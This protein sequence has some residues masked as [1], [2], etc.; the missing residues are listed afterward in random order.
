MQEF[1]PTFTD[2]S[3]WNIIPYT[4]TGGTRSKQIAIHPYTEKQ[5]FFKGSKVVKE[6]GEIKYPT[7]F[8]SEIVSSKIGQY[9]GFTVL[10]YNIG[11]SEHN[12]QKV[13]CLSQ[14][15][16]EHSVNR[17]TEG[18]TYL[19]G[20]KPSYRPALKDHQVQYTFQFICEALNSF[21]LNEHIDNIIELV[22]F[23]SIISNS[24]RHQENWGIITHFNETL[25][26]LDKQIEISKRSWFKRN[27]LKLERWLAN[28]ISKNHSFLIKS[29]QRMLPLQSMIAPH[30]FAPIYDSGCCLGREIEDDKVVQYL[31]DKQLFDSYINK[32]VAEIRWEGY[33]KKLNHFELV[34]CLLDSHTEKV[35]QVIDQVNAHVDHGVI[36]EII[37]S[38]DSNL[39]DSLLAFRLTDERKELMNKIV[40]L[41]LEKLNGVR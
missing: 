15:M 32:G 22:I 21:E 20:F 23:D 25:S 34:K 33:S 7:E 17:L 30:Q 18:V 29:P 5:F 36:K 28:F 12:I 41:R 31:K 9:L 2:I 1:I 10:D 13:G 39:P 11:Y 6:T 24:D 40:H 37:F 27:S 38:I 26:I 3:G 14:S 8:W 4:N 19:T 16:I 35:N